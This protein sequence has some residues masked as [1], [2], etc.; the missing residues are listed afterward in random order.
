MISLR[1]LNSLSDIKYCEIF[2]EEH[3]LYQLKKEKE[4]A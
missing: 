1:K 4:I 2:L 3:L